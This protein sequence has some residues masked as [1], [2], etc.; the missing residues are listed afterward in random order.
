M[1]TVF[2]AA[3]VALGALLLAAGGLL[4]LVWAFGGIQDPAEQGVPPAWRSCMDSAQARYG[5]GP[6]TDSTSPNPFT[7]CATVTK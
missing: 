1:K 2:I 5:S 7:I 3:V 6:Y 4:L